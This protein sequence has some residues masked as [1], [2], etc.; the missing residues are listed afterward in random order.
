M[1]YYCARAR[2]LLLDSFSFLALVFY[3]DF[4]LTICFSFCFFFIFLGKL[5]TPFCA[6]RGFSWCLVVITDARFAGSRDS[7]GTVNSWKLRRE[8]NVEKVER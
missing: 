3:F 1:V 8:I 4:F 6:V 7:K 2:A 5:C